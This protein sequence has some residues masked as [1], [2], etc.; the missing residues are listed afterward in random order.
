MKKNALILLFT[1]TVISFVTII[2]FAIKNT[3]S[4]IETGTA[5]S[6]P[7]QAIESKTSKNYITQ[8]GKLITV[9]NIHPNGESLSTITITSNDFASSASITLEKNTLTNAFLADL[10]NDGFDELYLVTEAAGSGSYGDIIGFASDKDIILVPIA[11]AD[12][13]EDDTVAGGIFEGYEGHDRITFKNGIL[14]REFPVT[15]EEATS[16]S[17]KIITKKITY[18]L[19]SEGGDYVLVAHTTQD[20]I[21]TLPPKESVA[22]TTSTSTKPEELTRTSGWVWRY[23]KSVDGKQVQAPIGDKFILTLK[24][25][26]TLHSTTDCNSLS[27]SYTTSKDILVFSSLISTLMFCENSHESDY[28]KKLTETMAYELKGNTLHLI[29]AKN[30]GTL[31]FTAK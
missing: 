27:G 13:K 9:E 1:L 5:S 20:T 28:V 16:G 26:K 6:T 24:K 10:N 19:E 21:T 29:L 7:T 3:R 4:F 8:T 12:I 31:V 18:T 30:T 2:Y 15:T 17:P 25:D 22:A 14:T 11:V 23:T